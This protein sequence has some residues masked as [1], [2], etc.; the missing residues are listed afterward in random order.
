VKIV[1]LS[2]PYVGQL[3]KSQFRTTDTRKNKSFLIPFKQGPTLCRKIF[4][5]DFVERFRSSRMLGRVDC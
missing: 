2:I 5:T 4:Q 3:L 1:V